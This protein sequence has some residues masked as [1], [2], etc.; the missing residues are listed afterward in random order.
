MLAGYETHELLSRA[1]RGHNVSCTLMLGPY[2]GYRI[3]PLP[4]FTTLVLPSDYI[5]LLSLFPFPV[6][7]LLSLLSSYL[8]SLI[9]SS[10]PPPHTHTQTCR[11]PLHQG[12]VVQTG[13][14]G[15]PVCEAVCHGHCVSLPDR[16]PP[17]GGAADYCLPRPE[18]LSFTISV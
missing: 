6:F 14:S 12:D 17:S 7:I 5:F 4:S 1:K 13:A 11:N 9:S 8:I 18:G 2:S 3:V 15:T 16:N 10:S